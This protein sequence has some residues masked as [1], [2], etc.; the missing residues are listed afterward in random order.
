MFIQ[1]S[2]NSYAEIEA[3]RTAREN[4]RKF[5]ISF[6]DDA[7]I[8]IAPG[9]LVL[10]GSPSG[11]GKT[12]LCCNIALANIQDGRRVHFIAL[13]AD[14]YEIERR[15]K[16]QIIAR[17]FFALENR[18]I[19]GGKLSFDRW[20]LGDFLLPLGDLEISAMKEFEDKYKNLYLLH[21][22]NEFGIT[23]LI[24]SV[25]GHSEESDLFIIDHAHYFDFDDD[26][27]N[28]AMKSLAKTVR[29][30]AINENRPIILVSHLRKRDRGNPDLVAGLDEFHGSSDLTKIATRVVSLSP[31]QLTSKG[32]FETFFRVPKNRLNGGS[33]RFV[34]RM[35][36]NPEI[37]NYEKGYRLGHSN[38]TKDATRDSGFQDIPV[39]NAPEWARHMVRAEVGVGSDSSFKRH[40]ADK[41]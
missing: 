8:G 33:T 36:F 1:A 25:V 21:S 17:D 10:L 9:D 15:L 41:D 5:G 3:R 22:S 34:A 4:M 16:F 14:E 38:L 31:G 27:E 40:W 24:E 29:N 37:G 18:P 7:L 12:Q 39:E 28:R 19:L 35:V 13:E 11:V 23:K 20:N 2:K 26:N 30:L 32:N 6:L